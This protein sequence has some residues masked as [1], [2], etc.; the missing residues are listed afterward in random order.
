MGEKFYMDLEAFQAK[1]PTR[2]MRE[3]VLR[4]MSPEKILQLSRSCSA[5]QDA[6]W[7]ARFAQ[8]AAERNA[9]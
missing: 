5:L 9:A 2:E 1:Y 4:Q 8:E 7:Y 6:I 3:Q